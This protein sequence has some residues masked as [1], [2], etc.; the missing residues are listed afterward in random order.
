M[1][2]ADQAIADCVDAILV[3]TQ[4]CGE[5]VLKK[6]RRLGAGDVALLAAAGI[7]HLTVARLEA[8]DIAEDRAAHELALVLARP[9]LR[10]DPPFTGRSNIY[11]EADGILAPNAEAIGEIN[12]VSENITIAT[13]PAFTPVKS[14]QMVGTVKIIPFAVKRAD[15]ER[16]IA[17]ARETTVL[18]LAPFRARPVALIQTELHGMKP[19]LFD[20]AVAV[21]NERLAALNNPPVADAR[22]PHETAPLTAAIAQAERQ[23][24]EMILVLGASAIADRHDVIPAAIEAA[25]GKVLRF[26]MPVDPGNLL[27]LGELAG[28][29]VLGLPGCARSPKINGFDWVLQ[30][31]I[32]DLPVG[33]DDIAAMGVG[34]L[35]GEIPSRPQ[36]R[37]QRPADTKRAASGPQIAGIILAAGR[38]SRMGRNKLLLELDGK[39]ILAHAVDH[40][41]QAG[42]SEIVVVTGHQASKVRAILGERPVKVIEAREHRLGMSASLKA[43]LRALSPK[44]EAALV[45]LG[46][47]PQVAPALLRRLIGA[48]NPTEGR[49]IVLPTVEGKRGNP[50]LF[51][52][53]YFAEMLALEGDV[54]AR[55]LIGAHD[56]QV[57]EIAV[58]DA[59]IFTDVDTPEAYARLLGKA[60]VQA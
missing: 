46:D 13:L 4:R 53:R 60:P 51:D 35:L 52:R 16:C 33:Y 43:G 41:L 24:A 26:G 32:A 28:K 1:I 8:D 20:K 31:L 39:P 25:G 6:G 7:T 54:G 37:D 15:L 17:A 49:S 56:D 58:E 18:T 45:M 14:G 2:F 34:G 50:V 23:G 22:S 11:A 21:M 38:S 48:Y 10:V 3:H 27:V 40:A 29:P 55:H 36:P 42:L 47:M 5:Q 30:R 9:G 44:A 12:R 19:S 57:A 59:G